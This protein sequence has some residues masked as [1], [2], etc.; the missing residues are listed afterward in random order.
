[1]E[2]S[3]Q[4]LSLKIGTVNLSF[5]D[6]V[7]I[8]E[9]LEQFD[10][11]IK[12][13]NCF[14]LEIGGYKITDISEIK[15]LP[16][17]K[18]D[19]MEI[20]YINLNTKSYIFLFIDSDTTRLSCEY[21]PDPKFQNPLLIQGAY[22]NIKSILIQNKRNKKGFRKFFIGNFWTYFIG[23][24]LTTFYFVFQESIFLYLGCVSLIYSFISYISKPKKS[25][26]FNQTKI[27]QKSFYSTNKEKILVSAITAI[28]TALLTIASTL[29]IQWIISK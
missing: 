12:E 5:K 14:K 6:L 16:E 2:K 18:Y 23:L 3:K 1:M 17:S 11:K 7:S 29:I 22:D 15:D 19:S 27:H 24:S 10:N 4:K 13:T 20:S 25:I 28:I 9:I 26:I 21:N 8:Y